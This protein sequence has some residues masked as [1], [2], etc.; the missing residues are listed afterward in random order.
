MKLSVIDWAIIVDTLN[1][2]EAFVERKDGWPWAYSRE[3]RL[4]L[5]QRLVKELQGVYIEAPLDKPA[6]GT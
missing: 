5:G 2:S 4:E 6:E 1:G 3:A